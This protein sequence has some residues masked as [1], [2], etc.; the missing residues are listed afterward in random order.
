M[1]LQKVGHTTSL[2]SG[3]YEST[4]GQLTLLHVNSSQHLVRQKLTLID[5]PPTPE[6][7]LEASGSSVHLPLPIP[8]K[9]ALMGLKS[10]DNLAQEAREE[11]NCRVLLTNTVDLG[12]LPPL[13]G[14]VKAL[15]PLDSASLS[16]VLAWSNERLSVR[17][18]LT[19]VART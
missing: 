15:R 1:A 11:E 13:N 17:A 6:D 2:L 18:V 16:L 14:T 3:I 12:M 5:G 4:P 9:A 8:F 10:T 7:T 19:D